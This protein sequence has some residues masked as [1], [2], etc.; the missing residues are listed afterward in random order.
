MPDL[1]T[2]NTT[3]CGADVDED[4]F[5]HFVEIERLAGHVLEEPRERAVLRP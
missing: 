3:F 4:T 5:E 2:E 1:P